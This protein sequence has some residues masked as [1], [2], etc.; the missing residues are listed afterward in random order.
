MNPT[1]SILLI[2]LTYSI[3][4]VFPQF[5]YQNKFF[6]DVFSEHSMFHPYFASFSQDRLL[7]E[8]GY[9]YNDCNSKNIAAQLVRHKTN[10]EE[11]RTISNSS[12]LADYF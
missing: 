11:R 12:L 7:F 6:Q 8:V 3:Y 4:L 5:P 2:L 10:K 1:I 9:L